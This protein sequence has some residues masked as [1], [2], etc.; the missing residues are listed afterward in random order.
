MLKKFP[1]LANYKDNWPVKD[2]LQSH[3]KY[4][5]G[6]VRLQELEQKAGKTAVQAVSLCEQF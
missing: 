1:I 4:T 6:R 5:S 3:L 2:I